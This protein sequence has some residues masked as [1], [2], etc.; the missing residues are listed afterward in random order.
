[1][2]VF[3]VMGLIRV[4]KKTIRT[5]LTNLCLKYITVYLNEA[6]NEN[7]TKCSSDFCSYPALNNCEQKCENISDGNFFKCACYEGY[8]LENN[9]CVAEKDCVCTN[10]AFCVPG[11]TECHCAP[12]YKL[13]NNNEGCELDKIGRR[14][15]MSLAMNFLSHFHFHMSIVSLNFKL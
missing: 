1:M 11:S 7:D 5:I 9:K 10:G 4:S 3:V 13:K 8:K 6:K 12:G 14:T 2:N 15:L